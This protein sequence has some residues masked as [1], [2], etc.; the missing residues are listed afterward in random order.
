MVDKELVSRKLFRLRMHVSELRRA[1]DIDWAKRQHDMRSR[2][3]GERCIHLAMEEV[4][5][6]SNH[7]FSFCQWREPMR[8]EYRGKIR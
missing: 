4:L 8:V 2:A 3:F 7:F 1:E 5:D 6:I